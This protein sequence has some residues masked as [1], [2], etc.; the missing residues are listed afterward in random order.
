GNEAD[1]DCGGECIGCA[2]GLNCNADTDCLSGFCSNGICAVSSCSDSVKNGKESDIDC[3]GGVCLGCANGKACVNNSDCASGSCNFGTCGEPDPC[4]DGILT[5]TE[6]D[7]DCGGSCAKKCGTGQNCQST[8]D[9]DSGLI[10]IEGTCQITR[11]SDGDTVPDDI[12]KCPN[13]PP[14]EAADSEGCSP[15]QKF[16]CNDEISDGWR[17][18]HFGSVLCAGNGAPDADPDNDGLTNVEEYRNSTDP[19][20]ADTDYDGWNDREEIEKGTNPLDA[21][22]HPPSKLRILL[23]ILLVI[24]VLSALGIGGYI[25]YK[26]HLE[27][28]REALP[29][30]ISVRAPEVKPKKAKPVPPVIEKLRHIARKEEPGVVD[31]D[32]VSLAELSERLAK[33]KVPLREDFFGR[34]RGVIQGKP[35]KKEVSEVMAEIQKEPKAF[36]MLRRI[37]FEKLTPDEKEFVRQR[38]AAFRAGRLTGAELEQI[39]TKLRITAAYYRS[40]RQE[41]ERELASWLGKG[42]KK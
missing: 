33:E 21:S 26:Y 36:R 1:V 3:G 14:Y 2:D 13:T 41:L 39:L 11:D 18:R 15:S 28:Q 35:S 12:D 25:G 23:W 22:S 31:R 38:L 32:W 37:S 10:C 34:L 17:I 24:L 20:N 19:N 30:S 27:R 42:S 8:N 5:G 16:S 40:H 6:T 7:V 29:P 4:S 9:C